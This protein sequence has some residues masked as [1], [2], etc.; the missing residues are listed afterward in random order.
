MSLFFTT[1]NEHAA[2]VIQAAGGER[3]Q[4]GDRQQGQV[5]ERGGLY[6]RKVNLVS[7]RHK[8]KIEKVL[9][10]KVQQVTVDLVVDVWIILLLAQV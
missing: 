3:R 8:D 5:E 2:F 6:Q 4:R 1:W 10:F 7:T 9:N